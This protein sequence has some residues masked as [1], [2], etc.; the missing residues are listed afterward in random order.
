MADTLSEDRQNPDGQLDPINRLRRLAETHLK[1]IDA[2]RKQEQ[3]DEL[4]TMADLERYAK[5]RQRGKEGTA[6]TS[7]SG[8]TPKMRSAQGP[9]NPVL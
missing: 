1:E 9:S 4:K 8:P 3:R 6:V 7:N 2:E 5:H